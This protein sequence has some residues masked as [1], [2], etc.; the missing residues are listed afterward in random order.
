[1][2]TPLRR[3]LGLPAL[4][5]YGV[6]QILGAGIYSVIGAAAGEAGPAVWLSFLVAAVVALLSGFSYA[7]L[8]TAYPE[9]G[10]EYVY[11]RAAVPES[12]WVASSIGMIVV[13]AGVATA[14]TVSLAFAGYLQLAADIPMIPV[15]LGVLAFCTAIN[16]IGIRE[17][18]W[19]NVAF[20]LVEAGGLVLVI[21]AGIGSPRFGEALLAPPHPGVLSGAALVFFAY[22]GF[23]EMANL[24]EEAMDPAR[25]LPRAILLSLVITTLLYLLV[26]LSVVALAAPEQLARSASP[27]ATA[28]EQTRPRLAG[29]LGGIALFATANTAL[30]TLIVTSRMV[31]GMARSGELPGSLSRVMPR[32]QTPW[33]AALVVLGLAALLVPF[34]DLRIVASLSSLGSLCAFAAVN[35]AV[36]LLRYRRPRL[37]R[38][39]Q[40]PV[41]FRAFPILPAAGALTAVGLA[42]QFPLRVYVVGGALA[43]VVIILSSRVDRS[44]NKRDR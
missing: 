7:E 37:R 27:L 15:A 9:A 6:G 44:R 10:A 30:I 5:F 11:L 3:T 4:T 12:R 16:I 31:F 8:A 33:V 22:L 38:P 43:L 1:M 34:G 13:I 21:A 36:I 40:V 39:F 2:K 26:G 28:V 32:R 17:S 41:R 42:T 24:A 18:S 23:E 25:H 14:A 35:V 19:A 29:I 20:T